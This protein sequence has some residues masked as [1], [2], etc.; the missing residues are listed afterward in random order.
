MKSNKRQSRFITSHPDGIYCRRVIYSFVDEL[1]SYFTPWEEDWSR[2]DQ[3]LF[4]GG[5][6]WSWL[7]RCSDLFAESLEHEKKLTSMVLTVTEE[8][9][10]LVCCIVY[11]FHCDLMH[12]G[13]ACVFLRRSG[14][15]NNKCV[16][17]R[18]EIRFRER[19][20]RNLQ[21]VWIFLIT[22]LVSLNMDVRGE[23]ESLETADVRRASPLWCEK[24]LQTSQSVCAFT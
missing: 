3:R 18:V 1:N 20:F 4:A 12:C 9:T 21:F 22:Q 14:E 13:S 17:F 7:E 6:C 5:E 2:C 24:L 10:C 19:A 23:R 16:T 15:K 8:G 11:S